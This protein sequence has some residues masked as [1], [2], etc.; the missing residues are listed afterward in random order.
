MSFAG[1]G[2]LIA[3][4]AQKIDANIMYTIIT[5]KRIAVVL[6]FHLDLVSFDVGQSLL[7]Q[8]TDLRSGLIAHG[9]QEACCD[10]R[11]HHILGLKKEE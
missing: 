10:Y 9:E 1:P 8:V 5:L 3:C 2:C 4:M 6:Y 7:G 11:C